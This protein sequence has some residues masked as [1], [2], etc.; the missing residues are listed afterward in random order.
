MTGGA[1]D[2]AQAGDLTI[3]IPFRADGPARV[4]N[5][6]AGLAH[7]T[8]TLPG[9]E[10]RV[11]EDA[12]SPLGPQGIA[13]PEVLWTSVA[14]PGPFHRTRLLNDGMGRQSQRRFVASWD[15]DVLVYPAAIAGA[16]AMLR[17]GAAMV[18]PYDGHYYEARH[19][20]RRALL[21]APDLSGLP[22][23]RVLGGRAAWPWRLACLHD[24]NLGGAV[25]FERTS[26]CAAGGYH[27]DFVAWGF[28]DDELAARMARLGHAHRRIAGHPLIHLAHPRGW[29][30][31]WLRGRAFYRTSL[32]NRA[33]YRRLSRLSR[34]ETEAEIAAGH[35]GLQPDDAGPAR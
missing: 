16:L 22:P 33:L 2:L 19:A 18:L 1:V 32:W 11:I 13:G 7:L 14:N 23:G 27:E 8:A 15:A 35:I 26:F 24:A 9:V 3:V 5:L 28:E 29:L 6:R 30:S 21:A 31:G 34:D 25:M 4:E 17:Q 12:A 20:L 10:I